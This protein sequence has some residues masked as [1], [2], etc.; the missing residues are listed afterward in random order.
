MR[1]GQYVAAVAAVLA[2]NGLARAQSPGFKPIDTNQ[3]VVAPSDATSSGIRVLGRSIAN[4]IENNGV[5]R[6]INNLFGKKPTTAPPQPGFSSYPSPTAY[7]STQYQSMIKP[8][9]PQSTIF[10]QTPVIK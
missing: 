3:L 1:I 9:M 7:P 2:L 4:T 5:V 10:G 8:V 6:T